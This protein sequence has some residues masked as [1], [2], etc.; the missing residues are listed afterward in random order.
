MLESLTPLARDQ[1][2]MHGVG[3]Y[4]YQQEPALKP[5]AKVK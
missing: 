1:I 4:K 2:V 5:V 3:T